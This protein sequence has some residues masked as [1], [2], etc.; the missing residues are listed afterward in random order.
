MFNLGKLTYRT[1]AAVSFVALL[2]SAAW[3]QFVES[4]ENTRLRPLSGEDALS[5]L[6]LADGPLSLSP[7]DRWLVYTVQDPRRRGKLATGLADGISASGVPS[8]AL[9][10]DV[11]LTDLQ[12]G[13]SLNLTNGQGNN[14][15][16][17]WSPDGARIAFFS[18]RGGSPHL[19][20]YDMRTK[21][22]RQISDVVVWPYEGDVP[23]WVGDGSILTR[24]LPVG[25]SIQEASALLHGAPAE[26]TR[27][28]RYPDSVVTVYR[29]ND[30]E[31]HDGQ[32]HD[33]QRQGRDP[34]SKAQVTQNVFTRSARSDLAVIHI[35]NSA[36]ERI[37]RGLNPAWYEVS[38]DGSLLAVANAKGQV[39]ANNYRNLFDLLLLP[40]VGDK[41][42]RTVARDIPSSI[43][44]LLASFSPDGK[45]VAYIALPPDSSG[46][47]ILINV[48]DGSRQV[49]IMQPHP[50][51]TNQYHAPRWG[52]DAR[53]L[54]F[55]V[56]SNEIWRVAVESGKA[57]K[58]TALPEPFIT[59]IVV[60][61][62]SGAN[63][64][65]APDRE[66]SIVVQTIDS[67]GRGGFERVNLA[68]GVVRSLHSGETVFGGNV[69]LLVGSADGERIIYASEDA[70][71]PVELWVTDSEFRHPRQ[72]SQLNA[73]LAK[74]VYGHARVVEWLSQD[75]ELLKGALLLPS[76]YNPGRRYPLVAFVY[77]G[78]NG[79]EVTY[80]FGLFGFAPYLNMQLLATR[81]YAVLYP[82]CP[83]HPGTMMRD[84]ANAVLPGVNRVIEAG[85][86]DPQ[87]LGVMGVSLGG[88]GALS[89]IVQT[90]RFKAA[91]MDA[92]LGNLISSY[93]EMGEDGSSYLIGVWEHNRRTQ[94]GTPWLSRERYIE[95][96]P[97][98]YLD[99]VATPLLILHG[100]KDFEVEPFLAEEIFVDLRRLG[101]PVVYARYEGEGH[102]IVGFYNQLDFVERLIAWFDRHLK[103]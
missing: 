99:R 6:T 46:D 33:K 84:I 66:Q 53:S 11:W 64:C 16:P 29:A 73:A 100:S 19:W 41:A 26:R 95:N 82:D 85:I 27:I 58:I 89:L 45:W 87:R 52:R 31:E 13:S 47:C 62:S 34:T 74:Y 70:E 56:N 32:E 81:G 103:N 59:G 4:K 97:V 5:A 83:V 37:V 69:G 63:E 61:S 39:G 92:G 72:I 76:E 50:D 12:T 75:G 40:L 65:W 54:Y 35:V 22:N 79:S 88:Y 8:T 25:Q 101:K 102:E 17:C 78:N 96:S 68:T 30:S 24:V 18:D 38:P 36:V 7:D 10:T 77:P 28:T 2:A 90:P 98:F 60:T 94:L 57:E 49:T 71:H 91:V 93:G 55:V 86:A 14:W 43:D 1:L 23:R 9:G 15:S 21:T 67:S 42:A 44:T 80:R 51:F 48:S 20:M 3:A